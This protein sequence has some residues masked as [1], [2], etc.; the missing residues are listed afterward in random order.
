MAGLQ[1]LSALERLSLNPD[2]FYIFVCMC[3]LVYFSTSMDIIVH[4]CVSSIL[5]YAYVCVCI[6]MSDATG[7]EVC[8]RGT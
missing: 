6:Y 2:L 1:A 3:I 5:Q 4:I 8:L 7:S